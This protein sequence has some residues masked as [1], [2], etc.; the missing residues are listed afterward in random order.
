MRFELF[1]LV[2]HVLEKM[3][4]DA[5]NEGG[6]RPIRRDDGDEGHPGLLH[7]CPL[8]WEEG[9]ECGVAHVTCQ[10]DTVQRAEH[11]ELLYL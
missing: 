8:P 5:A 1:K 4:V 7:E 11:T 10:P 9:L 2:E 6:V 3:E